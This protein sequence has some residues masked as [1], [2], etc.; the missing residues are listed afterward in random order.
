MAPTGI[1]APSRGCAARPRADEGNVEGQCHR[2]GQDV[3]AE[4]EDESRVPNRASGR[5][6]GSR[7]DSSAARTPHEEVPQLR[8][9]AAGQERR[10]G[11][12]AAGEVDAAPVVA[13]PYRRSGGGTEE[14]QGLRVRERD[15]RSPLVRH[16]RFSLAGCATYAG[17]GVFRGRHREGAKP[18][19]RS[20][21]VVGTARE[22]LTCRP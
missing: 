5:Q 7:A 13:S 6:V 10:L 4:S 17:H 14:G 1:L 22:L 19:L 2:L 12:V 15:Q 21:A 18:Q 9:V 3:L 8:F 20:W 11:A 16:A